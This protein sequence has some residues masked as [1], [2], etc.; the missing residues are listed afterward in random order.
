MIGLNLARLSLLLTISME[1]AVHF[2]TS[3]KMVTNVG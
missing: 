1:D 3:M 2:P